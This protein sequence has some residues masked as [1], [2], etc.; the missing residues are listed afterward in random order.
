MYCA[1]EMGRIFKIKK[2]GEVKKLQ[3]RVLH[4]IKEELLPLVSLRGIGR[5]R[6][7][8]LYAKGF[9]TLKDIKAADV[10]SLSRVELIGK[11]LAESI[12][13]QATGKQEKDGQEETETESKLAE[14]QKTIADF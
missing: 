13:K 7:R 4:G 12:K 14:D 10:Q 11:K 6:A 2:I 8:K 9:K 1:G 5:V 3:V